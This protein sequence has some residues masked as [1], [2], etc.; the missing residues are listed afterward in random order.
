M[1]QVVITKC[2]RV[3]GCYYKVWQTLLQSGLGTTKC[4]S[5][6]KVRRKTITMSFCLILEWIINVIFCAKRDQPY[7]NV[8]WNS[9][10]HAF[11]LGWKRTNCCFFFFLVEQRQPVRRKKWTEKRSNATNWW[12]GST[13]TETSSA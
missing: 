3:T 6:Y 7:W 13:L 1:W 12:K 9:W 4:N 11:N 8:R 5:Y 10:L 2:V